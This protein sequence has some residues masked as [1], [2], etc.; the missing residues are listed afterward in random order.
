MHWGC[1]LICPCSGAV[2]YSM[3][4]SPSLGHQKFVFFLCVKSCAEAASDILTDRSLTNRGLRLIVSY[5]AGLCS[6]QLWT[7]SSSAISVSWVSP[8]HL[9]GFHNNTCAQWKGGVKLVT[10]RRQDVTVQIEMNR[11]CC[12]CWHEYNILSSRTSL[13][14][15]ETAAGRGDWSF[16]QQVEQAVVQGPSEDMWGSR[17]GS[18]TPP[19]WR[20]SVEVIPLLSTGGVR[21]HK[22]KDPQLQSVSRLWDVT[23]PFSLCSA[24]AVTPPRPDVGAWTVMKLCVTHVCRL[25]AEWASPDHTR[26]S[27]SRQPV[28]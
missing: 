5:A 16:S 22:T 12:L 9:S 11:C 24:A 20:G 7:T 8:S 17:T 26:S 2:V 13:C 1:A 23:N 10:E 25:I 6:A 18:C 3:G 27:T 4:C 28:R 15:M 19:W 21:I 14:S